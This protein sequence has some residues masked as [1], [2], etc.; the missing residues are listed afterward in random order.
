MKPRLS[1]ALL[2]PVLGLVASAEVPFDVRPYV[3]ASA[4][5]WWA[6][7]H[8]DIDGDGVQDFFV[9]HNNAN[10]GW[11]G[12]YR[13]QPDLSGAERVI[14]AEAGPQGGGFAAGDLASGDIDGDGDIDV[15]GPV[16]PGEWSASRAPTVVYWY[17][18]PTWEPH[19]LGT[20]PTF[21][22]DFDLADLNGDGKLDLAAT[23]FDA[24]RMVVLRQDSPQ[25]WT[26]VTQVWVDTLHEGQAVGDV[27]HDGDL[28]VISTGFWL[29]NPGR[30][31]IGEWRVH[32]ID[33]YWNSDPERTWKNNATKIA[34]ADIDG[35]GVTDV[36]ISCSEMFRNLV[37]W[38]DLVDPAT[39]TWRRHEIGF[40]AMAHTLQV[41][42]VDLDGDLDVLSGNNADQ[43]DPRASPVILFLNPGPDKPY[44]GRQTLTLEGAYNSYLL[45]IDG[46]G[47]LDFCRYAGHEA[48][49]YELWL[50]QSK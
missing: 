43:G 23:C 14:I 27:D 5:K 35:N 28:D 47:D 32:N 48:T 19:F 10:S 40:N 15:I 44:W 2:S 3:T 22:K 49:D 26:T 13:T 21:V 16:H 38:Y 37:A 18:N 46:D 31:M 41:G 45:D 42:D 34:C 17:E 9:I 24:H 29:E 39:N 12:Y 6:R 11:L 25:Q 1:L 36:V 33:P 4:D 50:N 30:R 20:F 8:A 7:S